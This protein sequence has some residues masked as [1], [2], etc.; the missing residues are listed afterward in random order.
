MESVYVKLEDIIVN[1]QECY[2]HEKTIDDKKEYYE[3][4]EQHTKLCQEYYTKICKEKGIEEKLYQF[5]KVYFGNLTTKEEQ[6][7]AE[8]WKNIVTFHDV[9][10]I[11][12]LF[13]KKIT[14][15][16]RGKESTSYQRIGT[17]HS[18]LSA[19]IY[20][21]YYIKKIESQVRVE[22]QER[23]AG[24]LITNS[25]LIARHHSGLVGI[26]KYIRDLQGGEIAQAIKVLQ[27]EYDTICTGK[28]GLE[29]YK[30]DFIIRVFKE[31]KSTKKQSIWLY[32]YEKLLFSLL[33]ASDYYATSKFSS[34]V[35][36]ENLGSFQ[37][38]QQLNQV[39]SNTEINKAIRNYET[40]E[41]PMEDRRLRETKDINVLRKEIFLEAEHTLLK[42]LDK[43]IYYIEAPTGSGKSNLSM[44]LSFQLAAN[45]KGLHKI[46]YVYPFNTLVE[47][48][49]EIME[50]IFGNSQELMEQIAVINSITPIKTVQEGRK[51][52][53]RE[54]T[55]SYYEYALLNRQFLNYPLILTTHV[56]LF[57]TI[58]GD[59]KESCFGFHQLVGGILVLDEIQSY[60]IERWGEI[61][62]FFT[63]MAEFINMKVI[64]MSA[65]L[66]NLDILRTEAE[67][68][69]SK[70]DNSRS[71]EE[72]L[73]VT[74]HLL[75]NRERYFGHPCFKN[76]VKV[77]R[78][79]LQQ[80]ITMEELLDH[81]KGQCGKGKK[82]LIEFIKKASAEQ[83]YELLLEEELSLPV[84]CIT[85][86]DSVLE[87]KAIIQQCKTQQEIIL[88]ST[89]VIEAGVD[90]DMDIGY[91]AIAKMDSEE[92]F[93]GRINR[94]YTPGREG[95]VYLFQMD[96]PENIY[97]KDIRATEAFSVMQEHIWNCLENKEF[98]AYYE[99]VLNAWKKT[100][101]YSS[102][103]NFYGGI[104]KELD[105]AAVR[106]YMQMIQED[107]WN[108]SVYLARQLTDE[109]GSVIDGE[110]IWQ[111][112]KELLY[113]VDMGFAEKKVK[114][115]EITSKMQ[116]FIYQVK[117]VDCTYDEQVGELFFIAN[118]DEFIENGKLN[119]KM[120]EGQVT[121]FI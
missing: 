64:I 101:E 112:Y 48:N 28:F 14:G 54:E 94:S 25:Y 97:H 58:F 56:S 116:Y 92:Q 69:D 44:N 38:L 74:V 65:T 45:C 57:D 76:R 49:Q 106:E 35:T 115:S 90:I 31:S 34:G 4:L 24:F 100:Y 118:G 59:S 96:T 75:S 108:V 10:K 39:F 86:D 114:M 68:K 9:G 21:D 50:K 51:K 8:M 104:V 93:M 60:R 41:Y 91:K 17:H 36:I 71:G 105:F 40:Q 109:R 27:Q 113:N 103:K 121:E 52:E 20:I 87:R 30:I 23:M 53:E 7:F 85:G 63:E 72:H 62:T 102:E 89:Q 99:E 82:V 88:V 83:F 43:S 5:S 67:R 13:Q 6:L 26:E 120:I 22:N 11:N 15:R 12:P 29:Q 42:N 79:L 16:K 3:T 55:G 1:F 19:A 111:D 33:V 32:I 46:Y 18:S 81:V 80:D 78:E 84:L 117:Q 73:P 110:S 77:N 70:K 119:K 61:I 47:Q 98:Q 2:A 37:N 107:N 66:P 95:I